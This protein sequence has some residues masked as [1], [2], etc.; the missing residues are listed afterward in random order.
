MSQLKA[1]A[2]KNVTVIISIV[3]V[4]LGHFGTSIDPVIAK[5]GDWMVVAGYVLLLLGVYIK[6]L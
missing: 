3:L 4:L 5:N 6:G 1:R 2:P